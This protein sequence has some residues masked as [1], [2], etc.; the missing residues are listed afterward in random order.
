L[1]GEEVAKRVAA[2]ADWLE[3]NLSD[4]KA[5]SLASENG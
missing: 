1:L 2:L 5:A 3:V 4:I